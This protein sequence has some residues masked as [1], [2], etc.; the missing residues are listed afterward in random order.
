MKED[1]DWATLPKEKRKAAFGNVVKTYTRPLY[2]AIRKIVIVHDDANDVLQN[3]LMRAWNG[4]D[5]FRGESQFYSWL[6]RIAI[7][8]SLT[9]LQKQ[10]A[11]QN[12]S[13][14][15]EESFLSEKLEADD[16]FDGDKAQ[17]A[18]QKAIL[19]LPEKQRIVFNM[20]YYDETKYEDLEKILGTSVGALKASYHIAAKKVAYILKEELE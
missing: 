11:A 17:K 10:K 16:F 2:W 3:T 18:L 6:Y 12:I 8:E 14:D 19:S 4:I 13:I 1:V 7:N 9:F 5:E 15:D 20:R